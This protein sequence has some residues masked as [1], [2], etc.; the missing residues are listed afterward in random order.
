MAIFEVQGPDGKTYEV[1]AP[2][3]EAAAEAINSFGPMSAGGVSTDS[4]G[5]SEFTRKGGAM[6][7]GIHNGISFGFGD[8]LQGV[9]SA[10]L[11][12]SLVDGAWGTDWSGSMGERYQRGVDQARAIYAKSQEVEPGAY[13]GGNFLGASIP[14]VAS[15][16]FT[17]GGSLL[18]TM[19]RSG[20]MGMAEG[21]LQGAGNADGRGIVGETIKGGL[22]GLGAGVAAPAAIG[23]ATMGKRLLFEGAPQI[24]GKASQTKANRAIADALMRS[25]KTAADIDAAMA[26]A[27]RAGQPE[28]RLMDALGLPGQRAANGLTRAGGDP[29]QEISEFLATRQSGQGERVGAFVEDAFDVKGTTAAKTQQGLLDA[30]STAADAAYDAARGNAAPVDVRGALGVIDARTGGMAG[31]GVTGD[32]IDAKLLGYRDRLAAQPGPDGVMRELSDFDRVL[33][34][35]QAIQDDIGAAVRA[36]RNNEAR[37]LGKLVKELDAALEGSS[38]MYRTANDGF[39]SASKVIDAVDEG[40][41]MATRGRAADNVPRFGA[42]SA[43]EQGAARTGYGDRLLAQLETMASPT[44]NRAKPLLSPKR[45]MEAD[46]MATDPRLY[47]DR[48]G[49]EN[50]MWE[51]QNRAL[52]GSRTADNLADQG[53]MDGI[54]GEVMQAGKAAANLQ[55][56]DMV[57]KVARALGPILK[58]QNEPTRMLIAQALMSSDAGKVLVPAAAQTAKSANVRRILEALLRQP[59][60]EGGEGLV[61]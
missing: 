21:S 13:S 58:G 17:G 15:A 30:R 38:D 20:A 61:Q 32:G 54:S 25:G 31:S 53:A 22:I 2:S 3:M 36:G 50:T 6:L 5:V 24:F 11:G 7:N 33:G 4:E 39:R 34:V 1:E 26:A 57:S 56:G 60:R 55:F 19:A 14:A 59:M 46:A 8:N 52:G 44:S 16:P 37:E 47:S 45:A 43:A 51:T 12:Q 41:M 35:K 49:R 10:L 40:A 28:F 42:M 27:V 9:K 18:G 48:M 29:G 23:G